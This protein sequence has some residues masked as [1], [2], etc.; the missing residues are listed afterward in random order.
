MDEI[1]K[2]E[3]VLGVLTSSVFDTTPCLVNELGTKWWPDDDLT[4][5]A[6]KRNSLGKILGA[7]VFYVELASGHRT[8]VLVSDSGNILWE[9]MSLEGMAV[10]I[11][12]LKMI[13]GDKAIVEGQMNDQKTQAKEASNKG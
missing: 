11:D 9:D 10:K 5:Y 7:R 3:D 13:D 8:R 12:V 4:R 6:R 1:V 2:I